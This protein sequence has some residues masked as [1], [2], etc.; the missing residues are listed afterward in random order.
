MADVD[1]GLDQAGE[2]DRPDRD[3]RDLGEAREDRRRAAGCDRRAP[4]PASPAARRRAASPG[5][6]ARPPSRRRGGRWSGRAG[7]PGTACCRA[8]RA[9]GRGRRRSSGAAR[10]RGRG[11]AER[12]TSAERR[13][14][15]AASQPEGDPGEHG[16]PPDR[17]EL[18][19]ERLADDRLLERREAGDAGGLR[20]LQHDS[21][22][23]ADRADGRGDERAPCAA[24]RRT[25]ATLAASSLPRRP[26]AASAGSQTSSR[27]TRPPTA[28]AVAAYWRPRARPKAVSVTG[29][30]A[31]AAG[32]L[33][34]RL[35]RG[36]AGLADREDEAAG[37]DVAVGGDDAVGGGVAAV[38]EAGLE[39]NADPRPVAVRVERVAFVDP[40]GRRRRRPGRRRSCPRPARR[41]GR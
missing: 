22:G 28:S 19:F 5:R 38:R 33:G 36:L 12:P 14:A 1:V 4:A 31:G 23:G 9:P 11:P 25:P 17:A 10:E 2:Q 40:R 39:V 35:L 29:P 24:A 3:Q 15:T 27:K 13:N 7:R 18:G 26:P 8:R 41:S 34:D 16:E 37:D 20:P 30:A 6:R 32:E 21:G